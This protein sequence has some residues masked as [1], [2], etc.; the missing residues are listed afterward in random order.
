[1]TESG[2]NRLLKGEEINNQPPVVEKNESMLDL[3]PIYHKKTETHM[4]LKENE[5]KSL[6]LLLKS[7]QLK[8][9]EAIVYLEKAISCADNNLS[10]A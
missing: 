2:I 1:M 10:A 7:L 5:E 8:A 4:E 9:E 3:I 6:A